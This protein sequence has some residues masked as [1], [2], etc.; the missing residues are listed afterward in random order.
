M[1]LL[2]REPIAAKAYATT[3][4]FAPD[5]KIVFNTVDVHYLRLEREAALK[6]DPSIEREAKRAKASELALMRNCDQTMLLSEVEREMIRNE[7]PNAATTVVPLI[8]TFPG[9]SSGFE[10]RNGVVFIGGYNH[11]PNVDAVEWLVTE[12][13]PQIRA[14]GSK[15]EL[16]ICGSQMPKCFY[17][18]S[19]EDIK[20]MGFVEN[21]DAL[22]A[23]CRLSIAPLRFGAG[24]KGKIAT[25]LGYGVP[26]IATPI[27]FEG[28]PSAGL[29]ECRLEAQDAESLAK[30][31]SRYHDDPKGW[32]QHSAAGLRYV[33]MHFSI[34]AVS[35]RVEAMVD[36]LT[37]SRKRYRSESRPETVNPSP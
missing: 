1:I 30:L 14:S 16:R 31:V 15:I 37:V 13:W 24:L 19:A 18:Y 35:R 12:I 26:C 34:E 6:K 32:E 4:R 36:R 2:C 22:F 11:R 7:A 3:R 20:V 8:R 25:S 27:A 10:K 28:M 9:R 29:E 33:Q 5:A 23:S 17:D 21:L